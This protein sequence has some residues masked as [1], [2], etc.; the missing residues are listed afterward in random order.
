VLW[1]LLWA[2]GITLGVREWLA[3]P[4]GAAILAGAL[5][6][7]GVHAAILA[8]GF[9]RALSPGL[10]GKRPP[11]LGA[12]RLGRMFAL[13]FV[14]S[15]RAFQIEMP[16]TARR[17]LAS[18]REAAN[19][20]IPVLLIHGYLCNRQVWRP[21][22][23]FLARRGHPIEAVDLEPVF[24]SIDDYANVVRDGVER[25][26]SRT[27]TERIALV[28]HSMGG[29]AAR[30]YL[31][32]FG[33]DAI[34]RVV[35]IG[36]PHQGT[37]NADRGHGLNAAQ[38]RPDS[39]WLR[40]LAASESARRTSRFTV[41]LSRHDNV[42]MPQS[43]QTLAGARTIGFD[44]IGHVRLVSDASVMATVADVLKA[45]DLPSMTPGGPILGC[46]P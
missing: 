31:R 2:I 46:K 29:L 24:T 19:A 14:A 6:P 35:T 40:A 25:L 17:P 45:T 3:W 7:L 26:R 36:S 13:E 43:I 21:M 44:G 28:C 16:W 32:R 20:G 11:K 34:E 9:A 37:R 1:E 23:A 42:V 27:G 15:V 30:V 39:D 33:D 38:M 18:A 4:W 22:A 5:S 12:A 8:L 41:I 10:D